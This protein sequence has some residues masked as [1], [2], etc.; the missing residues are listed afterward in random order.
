M[1]DVDWTRHYCDRCRMIGIAIAAIVAGA[2]TWLLE[3][4]GLPMWLAIIGFFVVWAILGIVVDRR[5]RARA[6]EM[7]GLEPAAD[8]GTAAEDIAAQEAVEAERTAVEQAAAEAAEAERVAAERAA[9]EAAEAERAAAEAA[10]TGEGIRPNTLAGPRDGR[11]DNLRKIRGIG[12][13]LEKLLNEMGFWHYDQI[14][15]WSAEEAAWVDANLEGVKGR[16]TRDEWV[17]QASELAAA[18]GK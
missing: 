3:K 11:Q 4:I 5:C 7:A 14:A 10:E 18:K 13:K 1:A 9:A 15:G 6:R 2:V 12:P 17:R 16:V 8:A